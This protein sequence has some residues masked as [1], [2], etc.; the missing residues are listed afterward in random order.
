MVVASLADAA[1]VAALALVR[2]PEQAWLLYVL[3]AAQFTGIAFYDPVR[4]GA[5]SLVGTCCAVLCCAVLC[6][7]VL[8]CAVLCCAVLCCAT[9]CC[10]VLLLCYA[11]MAPLWLPLPPALAPTHP[12]PHPQARH[13]LIPLTVPKRELSLATTIDSFAWSLTGA[14]GASVGGV[15]ASRLGN[16]ACFLLV[17][18]PAFLL[19][20][21]GTLPPGEGACFPPG[22][23]G[24]ASSW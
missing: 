5:A 7:A 10:A 3:L 15:I 16:S 17:R 2:R 18:G 13:A 1:L 4:R 6:C 21:S 24:H 8:C 20:N 11:L 22:Q 12:H 19:G 14:V 23:L 9:P